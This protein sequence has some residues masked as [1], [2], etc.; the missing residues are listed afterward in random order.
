MELPPAFTVAA[1]APAGAVSAAFSINGKAVRIDNEAPFRLTEG[2]IA[3]DVAPGTFTI[4]VKFYGQP[5]AAGPV[6]AQAEQTF[7][8]SGEGMETPIVRLSETNS[9]LWVEKNVDTVL[10]KKTFVRPETSHS[11]AASC[12]C[13]GTW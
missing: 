9:G 10:Q 12:S 1:S 6:L 11:F 13:S 4:A 5:D 2:A 8:L 7:L 3:W